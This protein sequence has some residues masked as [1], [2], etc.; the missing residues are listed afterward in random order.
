VSAAGTAQESAPEAPAL[1]LEQLRK[2]LE[3]L[4][5]RPH[6]TLRS[7]VFARL[8]EPL[9]PDEQVE[10]AAS[11]AARRFRVVLARG[12]LELRLLIAREQGEATAYVVPFARQ[13]PR[14]IEASLAGGR[15]LLPEAENLLARRFGART[16]TPRMRGSK[17]R[18]IALRDGTR[19]YARGDA[20]SVDLDDAWLAL[21]RE[22]LR[23][24]HL[25]SAAQLLAAA[26]LDRDRRG[27]ALADL[28]RQVKNAHEELRAV[29]ERR[30]GPLA[31]PVLAAWL[32]DR[33][34]EL[35]A[36][37]VVGEATRATLSEG[38]GAS[39]TLLSTVVEMRV[40]QA[41]GHP[42]RAARDTDGMAG[43][44]RTVAELG[45][46]V[47]GVWARISGPAHDPLRRAILGEAEKVLGGEQVRPLARES[48][49]LPS[50]LTARC[51]EIVD[52]L[53]AVLASSGKKRQEAIARV[54]SAAAAIAAHDLALGDE[55]L[56]EQV[57]M[58]ARL[59]AFL[60]ADVPARAAAPSEEIVRLADF[61]A[62]AGGWVDWARQI[63]RG[64]VTGPLGRGLSPLLAEVDR[65]RDELDARFA[66]AYARLVGKRG[67]RGA[68]RG[69]V[70]IG[71]EV[72]EVLPIE[73]V[74]E[75]MGLDLLARNPELRL[76]VLCMDG[77]SAANLAELWASFEEA[78]APGAASVPIKGTSLVPVERGQRGQRAPRRPVIAHV[79]TITK[80]S[81]GALFA[82]RALVP[83]ESLDTQRDGERLAKHPG[84]KRLGEAPVVLLRGDILKEG[85]GL[86]D[87]AKTIVKS[88][89][90]VVAV[91]VNAIDD[92]LKGS[93]Q[94]R[95]E[96]RAEHILPLGPLLEAADQTGR[97][98]LL[99][100]DHGH[101][102]SQRFAGQAPR[103]APS[104]E[105]EGG[106]R[107]RSLAAGE[108]AQ[109]DEIELPAGALGGPG[110]QGR[111][112]VAVS[113]RLRYTPL[114]HAGEH[115]GA[116][117][118]EAIAPAVLLAPSGLLPE[119]DA[120]Q[121]CPVEPP[122][123]WDREKARAQ[124]EA[125]EAAER[126]AA[127]AT[128]REARRAAERRAIEAT[129][130]AESA[131][132]AS[133]AAAPAPERRPSEAPPKK[134]AQAKLP[135]TRS[136]ADALFESA[137]YR[138]QIE[139]I[140]EAQRNKVNLA[141]ALLIREG[142]RVTRDHFAKELQLDVAGGSQRAIGFLT[143]LERVLN[144][145]GETIVSTDPRGFVVT[146]DLP[147]LRT[148]FLEDEGG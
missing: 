56:R 21:V 8:T 9:G 127:A 79:P 101:V 41:E 87:D 71:G 51:A 89:Q 37:A 24:P 136:L 139:A 46:L 129:A 64:D 95:V 60:G 3:R 52:A 59:A 4:H 109:E 82:G 35:A 45:Q 33:A 11:G 80:L 105:V 6:R 93:A 43:L 134:A 15:L 7:A 54:D 42:L 143:W 81:R 77:M 122:A 65:V 88:E 62:A 121:V 106:A 137:L 26:L 126:D 47:P 83:G 39:F 22:R 1:S 148:V 128:E 92:Q 72:A 147:L 123:F 94:L 113:E 10:I 2:E 49:R 111:L 66:S 25:E 131:R 53:G 90:R 32:G 84:V 107:H 97:L 112:A 116:S 57:A 40:I 145:G 103:P 69:A 13:L 14:D 73:D 108:T 17:L 36:M 12:E 38:A 75:R 50:V 96:L 85:G 138:Q 133:P 18:A 117:L 5:A 114:L 100:S 98:V 86:R 61:Q 78:G 99:V 27:P 70:T 63:V 28:L 16:L 115:G 20:A 68:L 132:E 124:R 130:R 118:A 55:R 104:G 31:V 102:S 19:I 120:L 110:G 125:M 48:N 140:P 142:G 119:L 34:V 135:F 146:L 141:I 67:D 30:M 91:V 144:E 44:A 74:V 23:A 76:L 29:L 58:A